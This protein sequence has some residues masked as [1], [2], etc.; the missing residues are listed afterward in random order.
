M[1]HCVFVGGKAKRCTTFLALHLK[2]RCCGPRRSPCLALLVDRGHECLCLEGVVGSRRGGVVPPGASSVVRRPSIVLLLRRPSCA[3]NFSYPAV[4][5]GSGSPPTTEETLGGLVWEF[6]NF[7][8]TDQISTTGL[9]LSQLRR[10]S[11]APRHR[12]VLI[13]NGG[14]A[15]DPTNPTYC[16]EER[17]TTYPLSNMRIL[18]RSMGLPRFVGFVGLGLDS[19]LGSSPRRSRRRTEERIR[20]RTFFSPR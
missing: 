6:L 20:G 14:A 1:H 19:F 4:N 16:E 18:V 17:K 8:S 12:E 3:V 7:Q 5:V 11:L 10:S 2:K 15:T 9:D 13:T